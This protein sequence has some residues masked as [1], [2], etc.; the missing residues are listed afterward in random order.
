MQSIFQVFESLIKPSVEKKAIKLDWTK[1]FNDLWKWTE[2]HKNDWDEEIKDSLKSAAEK[3]YHDNPRKHKCDQLINLTINYVFPS[4]DPKM[5]ILND[6]YQA[7][8]RAGMHY[9]WFN[10]T[11]EPFGRRAHRTLNKLYGKSISISLSDKKYMDKM[12]YKPYDMMVWRDKNDKE[13]N[14]ESK[15]TGEYITEYREKLLEC[16]DGTFL[17]IL[18]TPKNNLVR[19]GF[20]KDTESTVVGSIEVILSPKFNKSKLEKL[21]K[22]LQEDEKWVHAVDYFEAHNA[23]VSK[24]Y[25][26]KPSGAYTGD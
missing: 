3:F 25:D 7:Y 16:I 24:Y 8:R 11:D 14:S 21:Y 17:E 10:R 9:W 13:P 23:A 20:S 19:R 26:E 18:K 22:E 1:N 5:P 12:E 6:L 15:L 2:D 4:V